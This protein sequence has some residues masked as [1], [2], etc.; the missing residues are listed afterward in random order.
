[1]RRQGSALSTTVVLGLALCALLGFLP[2]S[3]HLDVRRPAPTL[4]VLGAAQYNGRPSPIFQRR[5]DHALALYRAG[6]VTRIIVSGG[7]GR[8]DR[9][10]EGQVGARYLAR[11]GV[12]ARVLRAETRSRD[13][14]ENLRFSR[15]LASGP[16]T[17]VTDEAHAPRALALAKALGYHATVSGAPLNGPSNSYRHRERLLLVVYALLG[18]TDRTSQ[19]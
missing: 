14:V 16:V 11:H 19:R 1:M 18:V 13:T 17:L 7:V 8:G 5:L 4:L 3:P 6:G 15:S 12:P 2:F 9:F 10:S